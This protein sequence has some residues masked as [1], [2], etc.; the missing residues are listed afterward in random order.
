MST[1]NDQSQAVVLDCNV[2][3][4]NF[5]HKESALR[6]KLRQDPYQVIL[7]SYMVV[8]ILRVLKRVSVRLSVSFSELESL[9]WQICSFP[10]IKLDFHQP[11][12]EALVAEVKRIPEFQIIAK[13]L[14]LEIKD[15]PYL[16]T[17]F[18]HNALLISNDL[19]S[20]IAKRNIIHKYL[21]IKILTSSEFLESTL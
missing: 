19:R 17:A 6:R 9:F 20:L 5:L 8:E 1:R 10:F 15:I 18:Q 14:D 13:L 12:T 4:T 11:L 7:T 3:I 2:W 16:V 21:S